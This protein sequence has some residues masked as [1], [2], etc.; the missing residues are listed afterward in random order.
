M[1]IVSTVQPNGRLSDA[2][3]RTAFHAPISKD[4]TMTFDYVFGNPDGMSE[5]VSR[6]HINILTTS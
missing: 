1:S 5:F 3:T 2:R 6:R 4:W